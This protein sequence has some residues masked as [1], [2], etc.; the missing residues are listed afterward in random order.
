MWELYMMLKISYAIIDDGGSLN[1][2][3]GGIKWLI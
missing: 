2:K 1:N 3:K